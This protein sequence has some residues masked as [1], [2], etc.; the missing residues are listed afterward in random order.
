MVATIETEIRTVDGGMSYPVRATNLMLGRYEGAAGVKTGYTP[1]AGKC[2]IALA[3]RNGTQALLV[4]LDAPDRWW[5]A[6]AM[7][8]R[9]FSGSGS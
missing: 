5:D 8:D 6:E 4:L 7:L 1:A 3:R 9:A 2:L